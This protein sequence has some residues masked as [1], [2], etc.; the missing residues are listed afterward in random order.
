MWW[1]K[2]IICIFIDLFDMTVG[3]LL[4]AAPFAGE[5]FGTFVGYLMFGPKAFTYLFEC[6]DFTEQVD[7]FI[8]TASLIALSA[9]K[10]AK[11]QKLEASNV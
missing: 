2:F 11:Q 7:G 6:L 3:R 1:L 10:D 8:P 4:F 9:R 5:L